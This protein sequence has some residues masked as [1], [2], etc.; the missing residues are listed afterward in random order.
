MKDYE[1][2]QTEINCDKD[3]AHEIELFFIESGAIGFFELL[4]AEGKTANLTTDSTTLF[5]FFEKSFPAKAFVP[6]ALATL[7]LPDAPFNVTLT[8]Y[9]DYL[10]EFEKTFRH[11]QLSQKIWLVPPWETNAADM[12]SSA[13]KLILRP[14]L[15]FGTG[16]H[17]TTKLMVQFLENNIRQ[18]DTV[19]DLGT[20]SGILSIAA[21]LLGAAKVTGVD[22]DTLAVESAHENLKL[23]EEF[24]HRR[25]Q[26]T[27]SAG[28][29]YYA[30]THPQVLSCD[31]FVAN[32]LP[33]IFMQNAR[34]LTQYL[35][36]AKVWALSG[37]PSSVEK[38][39]GEF[40][41]EILPDHDFSTTESDEW[42]VFASHRR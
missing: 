31:V 40:L 17:E 24:H 32:I 16:M 15:A 20:G 36:S 5:F 10:K 3:K 22:T 12:P 35:K 1:F 34:P 42:L 6:M 41:R 37:I 11:F 25:L 13:I 28:D 29:F 14:G 21:L 2:W 23:N 33:N 39:F 38:E 18:G 27:F 4:Y 9:T 30:D 7:G 19:F 8:K 26:G